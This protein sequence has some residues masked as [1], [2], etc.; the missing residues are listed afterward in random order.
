MRRAW[1]AVAA[2]LVLSL[3]TVL[4][5]AFGSNPREVPFMLRG[6]AAPAFEL[7]VLD[8]NGKRV[9]LASLRGKP[10]I[11][12]FWASWCGPCKL[13]HP[14]LDRAAELYGDRYQFYGVVFEDTEENARGFLRR[15]G[16]GIEQLVDERSSVSVDYGVAGVPETY[17][18]DANGIIV[19]KH[20]GP[21][22]P[23]LFEMRIAQMEKAMRE[24]APAAQGGMP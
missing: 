3:L 2:V 19:D 9:S 4:Y 10:V 7:P 6:Q 16:H 13:E 24:S 11:L 1:I 23:K 8:G 20:V 17:F 18:I 22:S 14:V 15:Y 5:N 21:L 12:N